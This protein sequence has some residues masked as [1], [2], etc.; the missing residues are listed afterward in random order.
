MIVVFNNSLPEWL[1]RSVLW[2]PTLPEDVLS[3]EKVLGVSEAWVYSLISVAVL[4]TALMSL[5]KVVL[6]RSAGGMPRPTIWPL[7]KTIVFIFLG[8]MLII[9][10]AAVICYFNVDY[11][12]F[13]GLPGLVKGVVFISWVTYLVLMSSLH[14]LIWRRDLYLK[15]T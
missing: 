4:V 2:S 10:I 6:K 1:L 13:V 12:A 5:I 9:P 15:K 7:P 3:P 14:L 8:L 11:R